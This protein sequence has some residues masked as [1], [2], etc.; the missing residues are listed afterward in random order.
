MCACVRARARVSVCVCVCACVVCLGVGKKGKY[1]EVVV[2]EILRELHSSTYLHCREICKNIC[3][4]TFA[5][6]LPP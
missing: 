4:N 6:P 5:S 1:A 2:L 3:D